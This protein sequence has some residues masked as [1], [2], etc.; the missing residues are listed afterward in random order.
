MALKRRIDQYTDQ[1]YQ[2]MTDATNR[3][4]DSRDLAKAAKNAGR[5]RDAQRHLRD[6]RSALQE[7]NDY[8][9]DN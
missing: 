5:H 4:C 7:W 1:D 3:E 2:F 9:Y 8:D 6:A